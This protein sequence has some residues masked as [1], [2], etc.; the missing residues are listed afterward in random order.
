MSQATSPTARF[1]MNIPTG[2]GEKGGRQRLLS[3]RLD[4]FGSTP[5]KDSPSRRFRRTQSD[6]SLLSLDNIPDT[7]DILVTTASIATSRARL[8]SE[9][10]SLSLS[11]GQAGNMSRPRKTVRMSDEEKIRYITMLN[12]Q[13]KPVTRPLSPKKKSEGGPTLYRRAQ[14]SSPCDSPR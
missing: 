11:T 7:D 5:L 8:S 4:N 6:K 10:N 2:D 14:T 9:E 1:H 3:P 13:S 12:R